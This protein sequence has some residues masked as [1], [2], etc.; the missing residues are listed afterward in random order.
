[1]TKRLRSAYYRLSSIQG[2]KDDIPFGGSIRES[3]A[4]FPEFILKGRFCRRS[5]QGYCSPCFYS[6]LP[7]HDLSDYKFDTGY[8]EQV[9]HILKH[10]VEY[11]VKN[12]AGK[13]APIVQNGKTLLGMVCTPT[14]S[15]FDADEYPVGTRKIILQKL[16]DKTRENNYEIAL[17]IESHAKDVIGYFKNPDAEEI[18][19]LKQLH[20]R[21]ILGFESIDEF[22][23]NVVY[24]KNLDVSTFLE[25]VKLLHGKGFPVGAF[26][27]AGLFSYNDA[28]TIRDV[29]NTLYFLNENKISPV[30]MFTNTQ[31]YTIPDILLNAKKY[32]LVDARTVLEIVKIL[33]DIFG[34]DM[35]GA[36]DP[37]FIADPKGGPPEPNH[38]IFNS[39]E[40]TAC[41]RCNNKIYE[42]IEDLRITKNITAFLDGYAL[43]SGCDCK[44]KYERLL[45]I[46]N[47][48][49][50]EQ[51]IETRTSLLLEFADRI[52]D[53]YL[54]K[55]NSEQNPWLIKAALLCMGLCLQKEQK[56]VAKIVN[57]YIDEKGLVHA[58]HIMF[59]GTLINVC[60]AEEFCQR[61]PFKAK[62][63]VNGVWTLLYDDQPLGEFSF[64]PFPDWVNTMIGDLKVGDI[65]RPHAERCISLW[66]SMDC[67]YVKD[68][69]DCKFCGLMSVHGAKQRCL[70]VEQTVSAVTVALDYNPHYEVNLSGGTCGSPDEAIDYFTS[71][72]YAL[73]ARFGGISISIE[74]TPPTDTKKLVLLKDAG[75]GAIIMNIEIVNDTLRKKIC[76]GKGKISMLR[77]LEALKKGV[78]IFGRGNVSS[79]IIVGIQPNEDVKSVCKLLISNGIIPTLMPFKP[80]DGTEMVQHALSDWNEYIEISRYSAWEMKK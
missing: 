38:H 4:P 35:T 20:T 71:I 61:S 16:L 47:Q 64:L 54:F 8:I 18:S 10:F 60:V 75:A 24:S 17:H 72:C 28:E 30:L 34:S 23:R 36:I 52:Q 59:R 62:I 5:V 22:S 42:L 79:V 74:C 19:L 66:P 56:D 11:V 33:V 77:Y 26:V 21:V 58:V 15:Y 46:D 7:K 68:G 67:V 48:R 50:Y 51:D 44:G 1:M 40:S 53:K 9:D 6:R 32:K 55:I 57:P 43:I 31:P 13:V 78:E 2:E 69:T 3:I 12:Q 14:G 41:K 63:E 70:S 76:P 45:E 29:T 39:A 37:W 49:A 25:A 27:F 65:V 73:N 80:L